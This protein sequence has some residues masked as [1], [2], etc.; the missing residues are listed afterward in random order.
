[1]TIKPSLPGIIT[2]LSIILAAIA[3]FLPGVSQ[4]IQQATVVSAG[5]VSGLYTHAAVTTKTTSPRS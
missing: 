5:L 3:V 1:M 4:A 2:V